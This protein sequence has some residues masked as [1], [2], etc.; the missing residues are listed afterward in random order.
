MVLLVA[1]SGP[2]IALARLD[3]RRLPAQLKSEVQ[4]P[5]SVWAEVTR[6]PKGNGL[7]RLEA[8]LEA[9]GWR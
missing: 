4:V 9:G 1:D 6:A 7:S 5:A 3:L 2:L 8:A